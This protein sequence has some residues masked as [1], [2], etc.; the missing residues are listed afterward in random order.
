MRRPSLMAQARPGDQIAGVLVLEVY[1][2]GLRVKERTMRVRYGCCGAEVVMTYDN[3]KDRE[4]KGCQLCPGCSRRQ[5]AAT[6]DAPVPG[7][8][9]TLSVPAVGE[10]LGGKRVLELIGG[11]TA[12][13]RLYRVLCL[14]CGNESECTHNGLRRSEARG[15]GTCV[16][17]G[18]R[19]AAEQRETAP[20]AAAVSDGRDS[21]VPLPLWPRPDSVP[22]G[23]W[24]GR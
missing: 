21:A 5:T 18:Q 2:L 13:E 3:L 11:A 6:R 9:R 7:K 1:G 20:V 4:R 12:R 10:E 22:A 15:L 14:R 19:T 8:R 16:H 24:Y 23:H 17:C